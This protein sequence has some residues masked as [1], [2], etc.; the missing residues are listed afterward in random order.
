[1]R[2]YKLKASHL[3]GEVSLP[4]SKSQ[5]IRALFFATMARGETFIINYLN[6]PDIKAMIVACQKLGAKIKVKPDS[7]EV[8]GVSG[9]IS[10]PDDVINS[11]NSG[12]VLRFIACLSGLQSNHMVLT[13]DHS[14]RNYRPV[15]PL[16]AGLNCLGVQSNSLRGDDKAPLILKGPFCN[17]ETFLEGK[18]SQPVS[19]LLMTLPFYKNNSVINVVS[20]GE[21]PW[22]D[23]TLSWLDK[24]NFPYSNHNYTRYEIKGNQGL[25]G[26]KYCVPGDLSSLAYPLVAAVITHSEVVIK[27]VDLSEPQGDKRLI[28]I[29]QSMGAAIEYDI[30]K[31]VIYVLPYKY[32][33]GIKIDVNDCIDCIT[34]LAVIGCYAEG[35]TVIS[36]GSV[37]REK[38]SN[39]ITIMTNSLI[40]MGA[41]IKE[42]PDGFIIKKS[43]LHAATLTSHSDH[44]VA[45]SLAIAA[46]AAKGDTV[47]S[48]IECVQK[49]YPCF[50][51]DMTR[52]GTAIHEY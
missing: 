20:S 45:M 9:K 18:D 28:S 46:L 47:I 44:R 49:S 4:A 35:T 3:S 33:N 50:F 39:R 25:D 52:L 34:I 41:N 8:L 31:K 16:I 37:A 6:S 42:T 5:T 10:T 27:G 24:F 22:I 21:H 14:I 12:Q 2:Y 51:R 23:L 15:K 43:H 30:N 32:L 48:D 26:F 36:G 19:G 13:G 11:G 38:E 7:I 17:N 40:Q 1:M 29:L